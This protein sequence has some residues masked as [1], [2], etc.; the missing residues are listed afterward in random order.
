MQIEIEKKYH[1]LATDYALIKDKTTFVSDKK[2]TDYYLDTDD[3]TLFKADH[4]LRLRN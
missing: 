3:L 2:V 4:K 1:L